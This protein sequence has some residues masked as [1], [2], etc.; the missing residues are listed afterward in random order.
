MDSQRGGGFCGCLVLLLAIFGGYTLYQHVLGADAQCRGGNAWVTA[1]GAR[2]T[3][4]MTQANHM[5]PYTLTTADVQ[6]YADLLKGYAD[7]QRR[8]N[9][10]EAGKTLNEQWSLLYQQMGQNYQAKA[11]GATLP[12]D[13]AEMQG[14][15]VQIQQLQSDYNAK[16]AS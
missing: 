16:C 1:S 8:S 14:I 15:A 12:H 11:Y 2:Y 9:P 6:R 7:D 13:Q 3:D 4:A 5:N 10:P